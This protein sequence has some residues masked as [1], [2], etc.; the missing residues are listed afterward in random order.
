[1]TVNSSI[2]RFIHSYG[3]LSDLA[4]K[5]W[6]FLYNF[7]EKYRSPSHN[8]IKNIDG[9]YNA[10]TLSIAITEHCNSK[11]GFCIHPRLNGPKISM[12][13][14][15]FEGIIKSWH[16][17]G[18]DKN[19]LINL[20]PSGPPGEPLID[21]NFQNKL[22][23]MAKYGYKAFFVTNAIA[24]HK[25]YQFICE[26]GTV[27][28]VGISLPSFDETNYK[29]IYRVDRGK[30]VKR[31]LF[32]FLDLN[33]KLGWPVDTTINFRN[34]LRPSKIIAS[35]DYKK[36][37]GYFG[38]RCRTMFTT[39]WDDWNGGVPKEEMEVGEIKIRKPLNLN[40]VCEG[41]LSYSMRPT[42]NKIRLCGCRIVPEYDDLIVGDLEHGFEEA[43]KNAVKI[44][45]GFKKGIRPMTCQ[46]CGA[47]KQA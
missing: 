11:C 45:D 3:F 40:R 12:S 23:I 4:Y 19:K 30:E 37:K 14:L 27:G 38:S 25:H 42:D 34:S 31:N 20:T 24:L 22:K 39:W 35:D 5:L 7:K 44:Q 16:E 8:Q 41:A 9:T 15:F 10:L 13:D 2:A 28:G 17:A 33:R 1:M 18:M 36:L 47:Y 43:K 6:R 21:P 29:E 46:N 26:S 32:L